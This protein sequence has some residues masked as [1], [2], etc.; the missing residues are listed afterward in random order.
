MQRRQLNGR[1]CLD[2]GRVVIGL[3]HQPKPQPMGSEAERIQRLL[4]DPGPPPLPVVQT[5]V[6][7]N[8]ARWC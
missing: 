5:Y 2:T 7:L 4:L 1:E 8:F 3:L 6:A